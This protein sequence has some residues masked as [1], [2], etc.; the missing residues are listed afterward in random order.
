MAHTREGGVL[1]DSVHICDT[2]GAPVQRMPQ[3]ALDAPKR[4]RAT[5]KVPEYVS[6]VGNVNPLK[7]LKTVNALMRCRGCKEEG[8]LI[9]C[10]DMFCPAC[11]GT[12]LGVLHRHLN[13]YTGVI[14]CIHVGQGFSFDCETKVS[15]EILEEFPPPVLFRSSPVSMR[16][17]RKQIPAAGAGQPT[18]SGLEIDA[19]QHAAAS[20]FQ[21]KA[22]DKLM[23]KH[24]ASIAKL[25]PVIDNYTKALEADLELL[26]ASRQN[27]G[28]I[29]PIRGCD[30]GFFVAKR[31]SSGLPVS[32]R[33]RHDA[34]LLHHS[35]RAAA[36]AWFIS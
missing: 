31:N 9:V 26:L 12:R 14:Q 30:G 24:I 3:P 16:S 22:V 19:T 10:L 7:C 2:D 27:T 11:C 6:N 23:R 13:K 32:R 8:A 36:G 20:A 25:S 17:E 1:I 21:K 34:S 18:G 33:L 29:I 28:I 4:K 5:D 15:T 35:L